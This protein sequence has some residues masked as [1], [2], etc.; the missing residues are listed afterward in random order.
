MAV[1]SSYSSILNEQEN[2][3]DSEKIATRMNRVFLSVFALLQCVLTM[4][5]TTPLLDRSLFFGNPEISAGKISPDGKYVSF[6]K[7]YDGIMNIWVKEFD[8]PFDAARPITASS[9]P[10]YG[11]FWTEDS[12]F[13]LYVTDEGGDENLNVFAVSP[14][15]NGEEKASIPASRNLTPMESVAARIYHVSKRN[16]DLLYVGLNDR[17]QAWHDLY[18]LHISTGERK[19]LYENSNRI[20]GYNFD[21]GDNLRVLIQ[22]DEQGNTMFL[23]NDLH[24][25]VEIY[26]VG[27]EETAYPAGWDGNDEYL[28]F[29]SNKDAYDKSS[30]FRIEPVSM[31]IEHLET[32]PEDRVDFGALFLDRNT[33]AFLG[34]AYVDDAKRMYWRDATWQANYNY[35]QSQFPSREVSF[36]SYTK[37]YSKFLVTVSGDRFASETWLFEPKS[38]ALTLQYTPRP[39]LKEVE[40]HLSEMRP[41]TYFSSDSLEIPAYLT[42]PKGMAEENLAVVV[43]VHGGPKGPRDYHG[44]DPM[45]QFLAN[46]GYAVL[47]PNFRA[48][49]GYGKHF[50]NSGDLEWGRLMQDDITWGVQYLIDQG[51][52][53]PKRVAIMGGSYGGYATLAGLTF[54]PTLYACG[55]DIVGPSNLFTLLESVPAYWEAGRAFLYGM[56][57][58]PNTVEGEK[59]LREAS[60]LFYVDRIRRP[61]LIVQ[62]ANDPRVK[63]AES[64]QIV[65]ALRDRNHAVTYLL[66]EDEGHGFSKPIN[67]M[68]MN[69]AIERFLAEQ[70]GGRYQSE[71]PDDV[72]ARLEE[73][74]V[75]IDTVDDRQYIIAEELPPLDASFRAG[76]TRYDVQ[77]VLEQSSMAMVMDRTVT[78]DGKNWVIY[79]ETSSSQGV[80]TDEIRYNAKLTPIDRKINQGGMIIDLDYSKRNV[81]VDV[82]GEVTN[83]AIRGA[84]IT[85]APA[86]DLLISALPLTVDFELTFNTLNIQNMSSRGLHLR[87]TSVEKYHDVDCWKVVL[88]EIDNPLIQSTFWIN[89]EDGH[90]ERMEWRSSGI[91]GIS[92]VSTRRR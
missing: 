39:K 66:A 87:V 90:A 22:T 67:N 86:M 81:E 55:I 50:L 12:A 24:D 6:L 14:A 11:Y 9:R 13:I 44:Y 28:Y 72:A 80:F 25:L 47:Q 70:L 73:L 59:R 32:D 58:D 56:V 75:D 78:K 91:S 10:L 74:I 21:R 51:I 62:G 46:R 92:I 41:L 83:I 42:I 1:I 57:G 52:A 18:E 34:T 88:K 35:L 60:P 49:G 76:S 31:H 38:H 82:S 4:A 54:T 27:V 84:L 7:A 19:L 36:T 8:A 43:L 23:R 2:R 48:S 17:D 85:D 65:A 79:E 16:P 26:R 40:A 37:D 64:D 3:L 29:V 69:A 30:L 61:L 45:V 5:Q 77:W 20:T 89:Q 15:D 33:G 53:D 68:A 63:Q 71:M